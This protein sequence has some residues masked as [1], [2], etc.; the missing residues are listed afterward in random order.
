MP[1]AASLKG[2][3]DHFASPVRYLR[4]LSVHKC[5][6]RKRTPS[7]RSPYGPEST[8]GGGTKRPDS[9]NDSV[10]TEQ[11]P[12]L[13]FTDG[14][15]WSWQ[16][17][18]MSVS[19]PEGCCAESGRR[20]QGLRAG[21]A[22]SRG[23]PRAKR[24]TAHSERYGSPPNVAAARCPIRAAPHHRDGYPVVS[25]ARLAQLPAIPLPLSGDI[26]FTEAATPLAA[27]FCPLRSI[28][29]QRRRRD[30]LHVRR[31]RTAE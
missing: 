24:H 5:P 22:A 26:R 15:H 2:G 18:Q 17:L 27:P 23:A 16:P 21:R 19:M 7:W 20:Q 31:G 25:R 10:P 11:L 4:R 14:H 13:T 28:R 1:I 6:N 12:P 8:P 9:Q 3:S 30:S 29:G